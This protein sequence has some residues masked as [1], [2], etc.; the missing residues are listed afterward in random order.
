MNNGS[1]SLP[2]RSVVGLQQFCG[3]VGET[4]HP[5]YICV[6][7]PQSS[8]WK[9]TPVVEWVSRPQKITQPTFVPIGTKVPVSLGFVAFSM[10]DI[11]FSEI[12]MGL[13]ILINKRRRS[14]LGSQISNPHR[15]HSR[16]KAHRCLPPVTQLSN[17][18]HGHSPHRY[19][20]L[21]ASPRQPW[22]TTGSQSS[23]KVVATPQYAKFAS[24]HAGSR[25]HRRNP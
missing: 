18:G 4:F 5:T 24:S 3:T 17:S 6:H 10:F 25:S 7:G 13:E 20:P 19:A 15:G 12:E 16:Q 8:R 14:K 9:T 1:I 22:Y 23:F 21:P 11:L 2:Q